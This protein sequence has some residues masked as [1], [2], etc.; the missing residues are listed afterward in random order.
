MD[1]EKKK[2][3]R[4]LNT[5]DKYIIFCLTFI[6]IYTIVHTIIFAITGMEAGILDGLVFGLLGSEMLMCFL[7]KRFKFH[8]EA[9]LI[10]GKKKKE[11][12]FEAD[13]PYTDEM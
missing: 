9:K 5:L 6:S 7:I 10:F 11:N 8:E 13:A 2:E 3:K 12:T 1:E 4:K